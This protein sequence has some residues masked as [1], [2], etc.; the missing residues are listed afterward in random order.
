MAIDN[1]FVKS[2]HHIK[3]EVT[4]RQHFAELALDVNH[5]ENGGAY[6]RISEVKR[7]YEEVGS[8]TDLPLA[9]DPVVVEVV[10]PE[11]EE[12]PSQPKPKPVAAK[13]TRKPA[14]KKATPKSPSP[15]TKS[16]RTR[17]RVKK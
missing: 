11:E 3:G 14:A 13:R 2:V 12:V 15:Q 5:M 9:D 4:V 16:T 10:V 7:Y 6:C 8:V 17:T 1:P